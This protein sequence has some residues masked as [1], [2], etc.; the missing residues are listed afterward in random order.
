V[1][2]AV[3]SARLRDWA[4]K[5]DASAGF[6]GPRSVTWKVN[7]EAAIYLG[8]MRALLMQIAHPKVAQGVADHSNFRAD[9]FARLRRTF[10][11]V[12]AMVFGTREDALAAAE[13]LYAVHERVRGRLSR[14]GG[15]AGAYSANDPE[16]LLW[17]LATLVDSS[18]H[19]YETFFQPLR[20]AE[21]NAFYEEAKV[22]ARLCGLEGGDVPP[23][24]GAFETY[25]ERMIASQEIAVTPVA[26][27][28]ADA[29][30]KGPPLLRLFRPSN[31]VLAA[32]MLPPPLR[33]QYAL[34]WTFP[35]RAAFHVGVG[36]VRRVTPHLPPQ[37][38]YIP[39]ARRAE[40]R[41]AAH[42]RLA[43]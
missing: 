37:V 36:I 26:R 19:A 3:F 13:R 15:A 34:S 32:G 14:G 25:V 21:R 29:L 31:Y 17:V 24:L 8:G 30:L 9:P 41:C 12:H 6:Y 39:S 18:L 10:D 35:V 7:R 5:T 22:F 2:L 1:S 16:L 28:I 42:T 11:T 27:E 20:T 4:A 38:R 40:R 33:S 23:T 43:A